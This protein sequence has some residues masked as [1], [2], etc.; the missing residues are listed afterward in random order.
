MPIRYRCKRC[1]FVLFEFNRV[2]QD[3]WGVPTPEEVYRLSGGVCPRC[4]SLLD[5]PGPGEIR[6][7]IEIRPAVTLRYTVPRTVPS[8]PA[9]ARP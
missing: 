9:A 3:Y 7:R 2:G 6:S 8:E 1:G 5:I 4:K